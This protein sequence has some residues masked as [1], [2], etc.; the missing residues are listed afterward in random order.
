MLS[1]KKKERQR[2]K[3]KKKLDKGVRNKSMKRLVT[4]QKANM[5]LEVLKSL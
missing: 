1:E 2:G 3:N 4:L 5:I